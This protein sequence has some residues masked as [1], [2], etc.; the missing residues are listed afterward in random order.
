MQNGQ[1]VPMSPRERFPLFWD[2][3]FFSLSRHEPAGAELST[4]RDDAMP[5]ARRRGVASVS[6]KKRQEGVKCRIGSRI[7]T[8]KMS[9]EKESN[10][11][12]KDNPCNATHVANKLFLRL[13][14]VRQDE[15]GDPK[16]ELS[17]ESRVLNQ[18][19][20]ESGKSRRLTCK[21][22]LQSRK[23]SVA[24][25]VLHMF[26]TV[27]APTRGSMPGPNALCEGSPVCGSVV[28]GWGLGPRGRWRHILRWSNPCP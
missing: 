12:I 24:H 22:W 16:I 10:G 20:R 4:F 18:P 23:C 14:C 6:K 11:I 26:G 5:I 1:G 28:I 7:R 19:K 2:F 15:A 3:E 8:N 27:N 25:V 13:K 21:N 17:A 9:N